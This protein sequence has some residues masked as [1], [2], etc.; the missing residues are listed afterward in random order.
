MTRKNYDKFLSLY[1]KDLKKDY[2]IQNYETDPNFLRSF[3]RIRKNGTIYKQL[4]YRYLDIHH[5]VFLDIFPFDNVYSN[6]NKE[7][8]R[9]Q[10]L[11]KLQHLNYIK[12]F[13]MATDANIVKRGIQKIADKAIPTLKFNRYITKVLTKR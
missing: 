6:K 5:E 3:T 8:I 13:S 9:Y 1:S 4:S 10:Y 11:N 12:H 7:N 2:F